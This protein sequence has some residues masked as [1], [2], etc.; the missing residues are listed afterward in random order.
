MISW[1]QGLARGACVWRA[2]LNLDGLVDVAFLA[3]SR[4]NHGGANGQVMLYIPYRVDG[5]Q[6]SAFYGRA[7]EHP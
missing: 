5:L 3:G 1:S 6:F 2:T 4:G 7:R